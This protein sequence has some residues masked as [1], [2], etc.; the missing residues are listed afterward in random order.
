[1]ENAGRRRDAAPIQPK[2]IKKRADFLAAQSGERAGTPSFLLVRARSPI[3]A[4]HEAHRPAEDLE[5]GEIR[6]GFTV[7]KKLGKA[8]R[9]NRIR[10]RLRAAA[11]LILPAQAAPGYD[12]VLI[13]RPDA[14]TRPFPLL[15]DDLKRGLL[16]LGA[17]PK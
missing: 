16:R 15:L 14:A 3:K 5:A 8:V 10:R 1:M 11:A 2:T 12:Y 13:A 4:G 17:H 7:T 9:R 6:F